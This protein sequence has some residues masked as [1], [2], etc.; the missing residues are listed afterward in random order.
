MCNGIA[1]VT[2]ARKC[3]NRQIQFFFH[4]VNPRDPILPPQKP[5]DW[6]NHDLLG[7]ESI[8]ER[9][10]F[11]QFLH[12]NIQ[13]NQPILPTK[14]ETMYDG[15]R[16]IIPSFNRDDAGNYVCEAIQGKTKVNRKT[17]NVTLLGKS[18]SGCC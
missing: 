13:E 2:C 14:S 7:N 6:Q 3:T 1:V 8:R 9:G 16:L 18:S 12:F 15:K 10:L 4:D 5:H 17:I 11:L